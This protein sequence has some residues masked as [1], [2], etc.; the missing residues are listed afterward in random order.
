MLKTLNIHFTN[1]HLF[2]H[3]RNVA[4]PEDPAS[5]A[6]DINVYRFFIR[7][8]FGAYS[9]VYQ[10][11]KESGKPLYKNTIF[12]SIMSSIL[13]CSFIAYVYGLQA[14]VCFLMWVSGAVFY[15]EVINYIEHYGLRRKKDINGNYEKVTVRHS[16]NSPHRFSNYLFFKLQRHSDHH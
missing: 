5:A 12:I 15:L 7:S 6:K 16:W 2:G 10:R 11:D 9:K 1:E 3:H 13:F 4:T 8:Y 14:F